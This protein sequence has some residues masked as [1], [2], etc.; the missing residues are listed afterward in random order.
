MNTL[1]FKLTGEDAKGV[2]VPAAL[3]RDVV[4]AI[5]D[6]V[7]QSLRLRVDGRSR[8]GGA[9]PGW[10]ERAGAFDVE[11]RAGSTQL[12]LG[13][14]TVSELVPERFAQSDMFSPVDPSETCLDVFVE[15][16]DDALGG[17]LDSEHYD[18]G[19][20]ETFTR[21]GQV[22]R[23]QI[24]K[25]EIVN[26][27][28]RSVDRDRIEGLK[29]LRRQIPPDQHAK[30]SGKLDLLRHSNRGFE[31]HL[32]SGEMVRGVV[33][34][35]GAFQSIGGLIGTTVV[36][37]GRATF[38]ASGRVLRLEADSLVS[39]GQNTSVWSTAPRPLFAALDTRDLHRPQGARSGVAAIL[40]QWPGDETDEEFVAAVNALS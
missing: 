13:A 15:A 29:T 4:D 36:A 17:K 3:L 12:V 10:L 9:A 30:V 35:G 37:T 39:G 25:I 16:I 32:E 8:A 11:I 33:V 1:T 22:F 5:V 18:D 14:K 28:T 23:H 38:R 2:R 19:L 27:T 7:Q 34:E 21:F 24:E 20:I 40:G 6:A 31:L 26:G